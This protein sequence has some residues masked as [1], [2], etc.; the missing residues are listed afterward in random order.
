M[1]TSA[2]YKKNPLYKPVMEEYVGVYTDYIMEH[3]TESRTKT[4]DALLMQE[5][6]L[7]FSMY[8][9]DGFGTADCVLIADGE[10]QIFDLKYGKGVPVDAV[11]NP[12]IRLYALGALYAFDMLYDIERVTMHIIQPR[13]DSNTSETLTV[14]E[15]RAWAADVVIPRAKLAAA[16]EGKHVPGEHCRWCRAKNVCRAHAEMQLEVAK[17]RFLEPEHIEKPP[18]ALTAGEIGQ[19]L[20]SVDSLV[21]WAKSVKK[22]ALDMA[23]NQGYHVPGYKVVEG[24]S[25]RIITDES[26]AIDLLDGAGF[27]TDRVTKLKGLGELEEIVGAKALA[28]LLGDLL[29]KPTGKP[30][31]AKES[32]KRPALNTAAAVFAPVAEEGEE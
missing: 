27:T 7:D 11:D 29:M 14:E 17:L 24:R 22:Y 23:V 25:N 10:M 2:K 4:P 30:V 13:L 16:G 5:E 3:L 32:D 12:Q 8:V 28:N 19:I 26:K 1:V 15:L 9:P 18:E 21:R 20:D 31:L 6:R